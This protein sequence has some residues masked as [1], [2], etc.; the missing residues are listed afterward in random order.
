MI[1]QPWK[2]VQNSDNKCTNEHFRAKLTNFF[3]FLNFNSKICVHFTILASWHGSPVRNGTIGQA[4]FIYYCFDSTATGAW[5]VSLTRTPRRANLR[6]IA[7]HESFTRLADHNPN[8]QL[9]PSATLWH[10]LFLFFLAIFIMIVVEHC[11]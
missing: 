2:F 10:G 8:V 4:R 7:K 1:S 5:A 3:T 11:L 9:I 6:E